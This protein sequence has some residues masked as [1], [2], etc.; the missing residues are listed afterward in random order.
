MSGI[1][2]F[3]LISPA[4][5]CDEQK[6]RLT[7]RYVRRR[8]TKASVCPYALM[9][10]RAFRSH[11]ERLRLPDRSVLL[12]VKPGAGAPGFCRR[13]MDVSWRI[14]VT[15]PPACQRSRRRQSV[16]RFLPLSSPPRLPT[17]RVPPTIP[18]DS[19]RRVRPGRGRE[20]ARGIA[21]DLRGGRETRGRLS[22]PAGAAL[23]RKAVA[24][25]L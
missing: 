10:T 6:C 17:H 16:N 13:Q 9:Q 20:R 15:A 21:E 2:R 5:R 14:N 24:V 1:P 4:P 7:A 12:P 8:A 25:G 18:C 11:H 22:R 23:N 19:L 3:D